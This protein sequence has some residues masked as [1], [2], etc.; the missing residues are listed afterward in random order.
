MDETPV[1]E[2]LDE[3]RKEIDALESDDE[4]ARFHLQSVI[5]DIEHQLDN[6]DESVNRAYVIKGL[7]SL[8]EEFEVEHPRMTGIAN[9]IMMMLS[10]MGV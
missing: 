9:D 8:V 10:N 6:S 2:L 5:R 7:R 3:L 1:K 4:R